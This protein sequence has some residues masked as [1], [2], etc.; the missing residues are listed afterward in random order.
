MIKQKDFLDLILP[1]IKEKGKTYRKF[2]KTF[3]RKAK[4]GE[5]ITT[6]TSDGAETTNKAKEGD[7]IIKNQTGAGE[8][9]IISGKKFNQRYQFLATTKNEFSEYKPVGRILAVEMNEDDLNNLGLPGEFKFMATWGEG[10]VVKANDYLATPL[11]Q[12]EIYRIARKEF[13]ETYQLEE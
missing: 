8:M 5:V 9:Y 6:V 10:M 13:F 2:K 7:F 4:E 11:D 1:L 12:G 3:A